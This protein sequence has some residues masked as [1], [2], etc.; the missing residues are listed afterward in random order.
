MGP[1]ILLLRR[2]L[3]GLFEGDTA[4]FI[5]SCGDEKIRPAVQNRP[6]KLAVLVNARKYRV[7]VALCAL[8]ASSSLLDVR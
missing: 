4:T 3:R 5:V 1:S 7:D 8:E 2:S 6:A